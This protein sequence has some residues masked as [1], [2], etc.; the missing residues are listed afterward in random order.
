MLRNPAYR[1]QAAFGKTQTTGQRAKPTGPVRARGDRHGRRETR[2]D[3]A[4]EQWTSIPVPAVLTDEQ[5]E[6]AQKRLEENS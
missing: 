1:G 3:V 6:L 2:R 5:F 4:P